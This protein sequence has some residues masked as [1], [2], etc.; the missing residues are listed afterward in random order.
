MTDEK[1][2][3]YVTTAKFNDAGVGG[4]TFVQ[5]KIEALNKLRLL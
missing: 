4:E 3:I 5:N 1:L 2:D